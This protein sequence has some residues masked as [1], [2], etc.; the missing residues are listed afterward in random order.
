MV[1]SMIEKFKLICDKEYNELLISRKLTEEISELNTVMNLEIFPNHNRVISL[2]NKI[3]K[4]GNPT[5]NCKIGFLKNKN[6]PDGFFLEIIEEE[7]FKFHVFELKLTPANSFDTLGKQLFSGL[8]HIKSLL[9][10]ADLNHV[11]YD[12]EYY[13]GFVNEKLKKVDIQ[14]TLNPYSKKTKTGEKLVPPSHIDLWWKSKVKA[15]IDDVEYELP[16]TK[17]H[18]NQPKVEMDDSFVHNH[19]YVL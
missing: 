15:K 11:N 6:I 12:V 8:L 18:M 16:I 4:N 3:N 17:I 7:K 14:N 9:A 5:E 19:I 10:I 13:V 2:F 1:I